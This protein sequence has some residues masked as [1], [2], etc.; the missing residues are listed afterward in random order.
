MI[1]H[2]QNICKEYQNA[3]QKHPFFANKITQ[4]T[5]A[6]W[7]AKEA[8]YKERND[9]KEKDGI[10]DWSADEILC[11]EVAEALHAAAAGEIEH[12][13]QEFYQVAAVCLRSIDLLETMTNANSK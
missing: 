13:K 12:A 4:F 6:E 5:A 7:E 8:I 9:Q 1:T 2:I 3:I 11:E 10:S